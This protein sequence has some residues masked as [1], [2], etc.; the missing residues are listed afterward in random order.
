MLALRRLIEGIKAKNLTAVL[1]FI[2]FHQAFD[3]IHRKKMLKMLRAYGIPGKI[4]NAVAVMY[5][6]MLAK[7]RSPDGDTDFFTVLSGVLQGDTLA[8][9]LFAIVLN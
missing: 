7:V 6:I 1:T 5:D 8:P 9:L 3:S 4:V 2:D